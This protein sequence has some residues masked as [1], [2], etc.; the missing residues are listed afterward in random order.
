MNKFEKNIF[1]LFKKFIVFFCLVVGARCY[2]NVQ[3]LSGDCKDRLCKGKT[4]TQISSWMIVGA[5]V[6]VVVSAIGIFAFMVLRRRALRYNPNVEERQDGEDWQ[7][8]FL[9][10]HRTSAYI[11]MRNVAESPPMEEIPLK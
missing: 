11:E 3:C 1:C 8:Y 7:D 6:I 10:R 2:S 5:V 9:P 4:L